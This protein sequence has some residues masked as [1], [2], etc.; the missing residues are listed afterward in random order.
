MD[1]AGLLSLTLTDGSTV[2]C[3]LVKGAKGDAFTFADFT[4]DQLAALKGAKGDKGDPFTFADFTQAQL[5]GIVQSVYAML[6]A[7][8][9][10]A[11]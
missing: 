1:A 9:G 10:G 2:S 6:P 11:Y 7:A 4:P 8:E 3:G 5:D